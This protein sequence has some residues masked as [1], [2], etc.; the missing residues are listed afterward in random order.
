MRRTHTL[1]SL[2]EGLR[3]HEAFAEA[4]PE[5]FLLVIGDILLLHHLVQRLHRGSL[6]PLEQTLS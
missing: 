3:S 6:L 1:R 4:R 5:G 2:R